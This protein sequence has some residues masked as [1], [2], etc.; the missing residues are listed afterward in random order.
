MSVRAVAPAAFIAVQSTAANTGAYFEGD[1]AAGG[2]AIL[3]SRGGLYV[4]ASDATANRAAFADTGQ[5]TVA[6]VS[7]NGY[8]VIATHAAPADAELA[9]GDCA[10]WFDQTNGAAKLM[11]KAKQADGTVKTAS[12]AL[13]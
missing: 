11:V 12:V 1:D 3:D 5:V 6:R 2:S 13:A 9:A 4:F 10:L 7:P 8:I